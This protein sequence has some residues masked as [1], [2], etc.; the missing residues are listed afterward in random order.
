VDAA[1]DVIIRRDDCGTVNGIVVRRF[2]RATRG[3]SLPTRV[4]G[5]TSCETIKDPVTTKAIV[6]SGQVID[7]KP[8]PLW[9]K[10]ALSA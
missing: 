8:P 4:V 9:K 5:R 2:M 7:G 10:L 1:Q 3:V 6:K